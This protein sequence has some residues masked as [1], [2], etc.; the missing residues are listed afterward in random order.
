MY[1]LPA[2]NKLSMTMVLSPFKISI[3]KPENVPE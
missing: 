2:K 1:T 3:A